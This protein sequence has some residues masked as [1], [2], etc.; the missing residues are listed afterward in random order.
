M[1]GRLAGREGTV[2]DGERRNRMRRGGKTK[3]GREGI[4]KE[5]EKGKKE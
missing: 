1:K 3:G 5:R 4:V 2:R